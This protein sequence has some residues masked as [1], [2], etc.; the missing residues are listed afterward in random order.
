MAD[1]RADRGASGLLGWNAICMQ[2]LGTWTTKIALVSPL[3]Q[4][5]NAESSKHDT[6]AE[7]NRQG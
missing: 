2:G 7:A 5:D 6:E 3:S 4:I 1:T